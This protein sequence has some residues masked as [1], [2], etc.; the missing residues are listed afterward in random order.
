MGS[1]LLGA[2]LLILVVAGLG[3]YVSGMAVL[4]NWFHGVLTEEG[5]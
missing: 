3:L 1:V 5:E 2:F 4:A